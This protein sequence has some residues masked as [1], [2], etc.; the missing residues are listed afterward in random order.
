MHQ[1]TQFRSVVVLGLVLGL[2]AGCTDDGGAEASDP[3]ETGDGDGDPSTGDGDPSTGDGDP[4]TGDGDDEN[5]E[6]GRQWEVVEKQVN[7]QP[8]IGYNVAIASNG[9]FAAVGKV[10][11]SDDDAWIAMYGPNGDKRWEQ[12]IDSGHGG[13]Y[14]LDVALDT[15][16][17]VVVIGSLSSPTDNLV[18]IEKRSAATGAVIWTVIEAPEFAGN[19]VPGG[20]ALAPDGAL[21][22]S[23]SIR[24]GD[25]DSDIMTRKLASADGSTIWSATA[26]G[27]TD[28]GG[29][30][31]DLAGPVAVA[32]DGSIYVGG[33]EGVDYQ[34]KEGVLL[35][36]GPDG[37]VAQW[38]AAPKADGS[39]H[40]HDVVAVTGGPDGEAYFV[41]NRGG[42]VSGFWLSRISP[43]GEI[44][45]EM[46]H[47][48]FTHG[49]TDN[50]RVAG[51]AI[52]DDG[53][54]TVGGRMT[55]K[56]PE[57]AISWSEAWVANITLAGAGQCIA[58]HTWEN[59]KII[60]ARTF[61]YGLAEG[62]NGA[63]LIGEIIN[64]PENYLWI[65]AFR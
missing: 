21:V 54:L 34:T 16:G 11:N 28:A 23:A 64:G 49:V 2:G 31:I 56:E 24:A 52:A 6:C 39:A 35:K 53:L 12:V 13:D 25:M 44:E 5:L 8:H 57:H 29:F 61:A 63:V 37:G 10:R 1:L 48:D 32:G 33:S 38:K 47:A 22:I 15:N 62:P 3:T 50:W 14:A 36:Y 4:S 42:N 30:S 41:V 27:I 9:D 45:W 51:L 20:I 17:E 59:D 65:G 40:L 7:G 55:N 58:M 19:N 18:W 60:P 43:A 26:T 46:S